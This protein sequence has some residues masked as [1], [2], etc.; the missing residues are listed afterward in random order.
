MRSIDEN[1]K[2]LLE[3]DIGTGPG[4]VS[5]ISGPK[6][7]L[8][9]SN[10]FIVYSSQIVHSIKN[11]IRIYVKYSCMSICIKSVLIELYF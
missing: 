4:P 11:G 1:Q 8:F 7:L 2:N 9:V 3:A 10:L 6:V 5:S